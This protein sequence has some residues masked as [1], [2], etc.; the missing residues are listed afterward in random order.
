MLCHPVESLIVT[1]L[2]VMSNGATPTMFVAP[3]MSEREEE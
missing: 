2:N 1:S 3:T